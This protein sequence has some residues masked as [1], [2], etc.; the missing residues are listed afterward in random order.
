MHQTQICLASAGFSLVRLN[1]DDVSTHF[2][3]CNNRAVLNITMNP[4]YSV[5]DCIA[6]CQLANQTR[7]RFANAPYQFKAISNE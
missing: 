4:G 3:V 7:E 5:S 6:I 1:A 2:L